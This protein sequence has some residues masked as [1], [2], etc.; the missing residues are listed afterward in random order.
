MDKKLT[1]FIDSGDTLIDEGTE[2]HER[3]SELVLKADLIP[4]A[5]ETII[6]LKEKG[7]KIIMVA[8]GLRQSFINVYKQHDLYDHYDG[9]IYSEDIGV[10]KPDK[11]M[12][13]AALTAAGLTS[14]DCHRVVM[15]GNN[16]S[17]DIKGANNMNMISIHLA[18]SP[19][20][21]KNA[22]HESEIPDYVINHPVEL[23]GLVEKL[24]DEIESQWN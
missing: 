7:Y 23:V 6:D 15:V 9:H 20:Y 5:K 1:I 19:R 2:V 16:L 13:E 21:P 17:R 22:T 24:N 3:D 11:K 14:D 10:N 8:D 12:F 18:W 4:G